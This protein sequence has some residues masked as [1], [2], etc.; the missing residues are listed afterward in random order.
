[1]PRVSVGSQSQSFLVSMVSSP[2]DTLP[3]TT[4]QTAGNTT[5]ARARSPVGRKPQVKSTS[6]SVPR[7]G[8]L[9]GDGESIMGGR[10]FDVTPTPPTRASPRSQTI[11]TFRA[12]ESGRGIFSLLQRRRDRYKQ[13]IAPDP[14]H[15]RRSLNGML[16]IQRGGS[17]S[18]PRHYDL[19]E[20]AISPMNTLAPRWIPARI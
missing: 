7:I 12:A 15:R 10:T 4:Q 2:N 1:M 13:P 18:S 16:S 3:L 20:S 9:G 19:V 14:C 8:L 17:R 6:F 11:S 5:I